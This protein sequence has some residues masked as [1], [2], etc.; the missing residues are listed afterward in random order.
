MFGQIGQPRILR[1]PN[2]EPTSYQWHV[3][4]ENQ[5]ALVSIS[6]MVFDRL[7]EEDKKKILKMQLIKVYTQMIERMINIV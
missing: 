6:A 5:H 3:Q 4:H 2:G 7:S 1:A